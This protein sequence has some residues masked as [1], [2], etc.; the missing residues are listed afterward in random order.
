MFGPKTNGILEKGGENGKEGEKRR[1][2]KEK[3]REREGNEMEFSEY[4]IAFVHGLCHYIY[5][6]IPRPIA[7]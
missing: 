5:I 7:H 2:E 3:E 4:R 1:R 6:Y